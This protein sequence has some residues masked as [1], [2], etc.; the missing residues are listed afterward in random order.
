MI[1]RINRTRRKRIEKRDVKLALRPARKG[2]A[3]IFDLELRLEDYR[4][5]ADAR[6]RVEAGRSNATQRWDYGTVGML[7]PPADEERR[8]TGVSENASFRVFVVATDGSGRLL[9]H[10]P[11]LK[12]VLP[13]NSRLPLEESDLAEEVWRVEFDGDDGHPVLHVNGRIPGVSEA[14]RS[15]PTFR[16][17]VMPDV[18]RTILTRMVV[19]DRADPEDEDSGWADWFEIARAY[20][21]GTEP[22]SLPQSGPVDT[23]EFERAHDWI[24]AVVGALAEKPLRA[25]DVYAETLA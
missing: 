23:A 7:A 2:E 22:P 12:P 10:T 6:V 4:F 1:K 18:F 16:A 24:D 13:L 17:L 3:P 15:D 20:H 8:M 19:I 25:A 21:S 11:N 9:G 14:V 5:P